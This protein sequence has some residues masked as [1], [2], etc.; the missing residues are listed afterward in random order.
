MS[1]QYYEVYLSF[2]SNVGDRRANIE[3]AVLLLNDS[4]VKMKKIS[5]LYETEPWG[6]AAQ[7]S[8]MNRAGMF[9]TN[10]STEILMKNILAI[11]QSMGRERTQKWQ[12]RI[13]DIDILFF[14]N[15]VVRELG[16][17]IPHPEIERRKFVL[18]PLK[19]IAGSFVHPL[20]KKSVNE[21]TFEC[22]DVLRV[23]LVHD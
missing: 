14:G 4:G 9:E 15:K 17:Q 10:L 1:R 12:P 3:K 22:E 2:G 18:V 21:L 23:E 5:S 19:E 16:L 8:F 20:L 6:N 13:I 11:E 7:P